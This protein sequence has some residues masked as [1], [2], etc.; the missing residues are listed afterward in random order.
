MIVNDG[1]FRHLGEG[2]EWNEPAANIALVHNLRKL[3]EL[4]ERTQTKHPVPHQFTVA[5]M[6]IE[7][8]NANRV[9]VCVWHKHAHKQHNQA[10]SAD[11][12]IGNWA[13]CI[14]Y[15][16]RNVC[17]N[18]CRNVFVKI[19]P[20][21]VNVLCVFVLFLTLA[22][23]ISGASICD[24]LH[25]RLRVH[26]H[27]IKGIMIIYSTWYL[28]QVR[29]RAT[30]SSSVRFTRHIQIGADKEREREREND[31]KTCIGKHH[32]QGCT[33]EE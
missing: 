16:C 5:L 3:F 6:Q 21:R 27:L 15:S 22:S 14:S 29:N 20:T 28:C 23:N 4:L 10:T 12:M 26:F 32:I 33:V 7:K 19:A 18:T 11:D 9:C 8:C 13:V 25:A 1:W 2:D 17:P 24:A 31:W 30:K